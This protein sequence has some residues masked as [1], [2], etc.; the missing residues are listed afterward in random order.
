MMGPA[1]HRREAEKLLGQ[2][3][4]VTEQFASYLV[5]KAQAHATIAVALSMEERSVTVNTEA[6]A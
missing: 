6:R 3:L 5:A 4:E 2:S 1:E